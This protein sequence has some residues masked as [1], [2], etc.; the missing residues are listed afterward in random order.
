MCALKPEP[1]ARKAF[2]S[3]THRDG[4]T[5]LLPEGQWRPHIIQWTPHVRGLCMDSWLMLPHK[6]RLA[7]TACEDESW[8]GEANLKTGCG[9]RTT[10]TPSRKEEEEPG[11]RFMLPPPSL[12]AQPCSSAR[13]RACSSSSCR[14]TDR[15]SFLCNLAQSRWS[16]SLETMLCGAFIHGC[17]CY[18]SSSSSI[19]ARLASNAFPF[20]WARVG[21]N[22]ATWEREISPSQ[23]RQGLRQIHSLA[24]T[25]AFSHSFSHTLRRWFLYF[26]PQ[27][28]FGLPRGG[29]DCDFFFLFVLCPLFSIWMCLFGCDV[30]SRVITGKC[31][32]F[33]DGWVERT[34]ELRKLNGVHEFHYAWVLGGSWNHLKPFSFY[35]I[36]IFIYIFILDI[37]NVITIFAIATTCH[38]H[39]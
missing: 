20:L 15:H 1:A 2:F 37:V 5:P 12:R 31:T 36:H 33:V 32:I 17:Y 11:T 6:A 8:L 10:P 7:M 23:G 22:P 18:C 29:G 14:E 30:L 28:H 9:P 19:V 34:L 13:K 25:L 3:H 38:S 21:Y 26:V 24:C 16:L 39:H 27:H 4:F 35:A